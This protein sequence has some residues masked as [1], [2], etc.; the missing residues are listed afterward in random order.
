LTDS[1]EESPQEGRR[2]KRLQHRFSPKLR[3]VK[4]NVTFLE[5]VSDYPV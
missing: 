1:Y 3:D 4:D 5:N 2:L